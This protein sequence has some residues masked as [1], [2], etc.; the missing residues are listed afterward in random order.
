MRKTQ[1]PVKSSLHGLLLKKNFNHDY[2]EITLA[3]KTEILTL[4][5]NQPL[6][7]KLKVGDKLYLCIKD[8]EILEKNES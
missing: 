3:L 5:I 6:G 7:E 2:Y 8:F 4:K 1:N